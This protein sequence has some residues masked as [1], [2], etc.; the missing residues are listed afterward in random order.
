M[1]GMI[2]G[3]ACQRARLW[4]YA[5]FRCGYRILNARIGMLYI[6]MRLDNERGNS[7]IA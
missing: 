7:S 2:L 3:V 5:I 4:L 6:L 1:C